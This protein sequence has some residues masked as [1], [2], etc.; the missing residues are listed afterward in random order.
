MKKNIESIANILPISEY[1]KI[2]SIY[3]F[4]YNV[5][6]FIYQIDHK[7]L[8]DTNFICNYVIHK[9]INKDIMYNKLCYG[10][11]DIKNVNSLDVYYI[12][13]YS[14]NIL[15]ENVMI[16]KKSNTELSYNVTK[17]INNNDIDEEF[18]LEN[19]NKQSVDNYFKILCYIELFNKNNISKDVILEI[20]NILKKILKKPNNESNNN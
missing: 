16:N 20:K 11:T 3:N 10:T 5:Y 1:K 6:I 8:N 2:D 18:L 15:L 9:Q 14:I 19:I 12:S 17:I 7:L 13:L 4:I